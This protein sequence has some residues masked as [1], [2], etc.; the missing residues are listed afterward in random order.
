[1]DGMG[2]FAAAVNMDAGSDHSRP[3]EPCAGVS[4]GTKSQNWK[5]D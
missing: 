2:Q 4:G 3:S 5:V 1:M